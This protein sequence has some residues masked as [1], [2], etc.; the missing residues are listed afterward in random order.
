M[1]PLAQSGQNATFSVKGIYDSSNEAGDDVTPEIAGVYS[2]T[3][4]DD[5]FG[6]GL[7][8]SHQER[9]FQQQAANIQGWQLQENAAL[10]DLDPEN[11][12]DNRTNIFYR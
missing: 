2:N 3:F 5:M 4:A 12:V 6:F 11:V 1:K 9:D 10:P 7:S 8:F